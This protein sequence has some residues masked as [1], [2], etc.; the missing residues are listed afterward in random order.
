MESGDFGGECENCE[1]LTCT[2]NDESICK[3]CS[4]CTGDKGYSKW[5]MDCKRYK[6]VENSDETI[7]IILGSVVS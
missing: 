3:N 5:K 4:R 7:D 1:C 2:K 6:Q